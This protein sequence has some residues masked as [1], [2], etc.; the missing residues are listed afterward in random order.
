MKSVSKQFERKK[1]MFLFMFLCLGMNCA[2]LY[3]KG[4]DSGTDKVTEMEWFI[5]WQG[6]ICYGVYSGEVQ[7]GKP[8]G[9]GEFSGNIVIDNEDMGEIVYNGQWKSGEMQGKGKLIDYEA[10]RIYEGNFLENKLNGVVK[11]YSTDKFQT[12]TL[13]RYKKDVSTGVCWEYNDND[14][15]ISYDY[16]FYGLS[17]NRICEEAKEYDYAE[18]VHSAGSKEYK[19]I[20]L[21]CTVKDIDYNND[22]HKNTVKVED[23]NGNSYVLNYNLTYK[24]TAENYMPFLRKGDKITVFGYYSGFATYK[25]GIQ[26]P[27]I[28][29]VIAMK[30][31]AKIVD[32]NHLEYS[33]S[34]LLDYPYIYYN[35]DIE[36]EG[37]SKGIYKVNEKW[38]F[39]YFETSGDSE[40]KGT[41]ICKV[42]NKKENIESFSGEEEKI[43][44]QGKSNLVSG[45]Y[46]KDNRDGFFPVVKVEKIVK[47]Q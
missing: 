12:Y 10:G 31:D 1:I 27:Y 22:S 19:K 36:L 3:A 17:V 28:D 8:E 7:N 44:I 37:K 20:K 16:C 24:T 38:V 35:K 43:I 30:T 11:E 26:Y 32:A 2:R 42:K 29:A 4:L 40:K 46:I 25:K 33:Y 15:I 41:Y 23:K 14:E 39:F 47:G 6:I 21:S 9:K 5:R 34:D 18:L 45:G 13:K